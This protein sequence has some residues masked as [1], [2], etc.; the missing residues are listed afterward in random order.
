M[1][2]QVALHPFATSAC[3]RLGERRMD[4]QHFIYKKRVARAA[5]LEQARNL[6]RSGEH[7]GVESI[8]TAMQGVEAFDDVRHWFEDWAFR[9]QLNRLCAIARASNASFRLRGRRR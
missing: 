5:L 3:T 8:M 7:A 2:I 9:H 4:R 6:A 1:Q